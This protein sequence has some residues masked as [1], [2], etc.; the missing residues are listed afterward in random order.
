MPKKIYDIRPPRLADTIKKENQNLAEISKKRKGRNRA[1]RKKHSFWLPVL[2]IV[3]LVIMPGGIYLFFKLPRAE[4]TIWPKRE[5]LKF[6]QE[7][8]ADKSATL[9]DPAK[10]IIPAKYFQTSK[11]NAQDFP[12]TGSALNEGRAQGTITLYNKYSPPTPLTLRANT[13]FISDS[14]KIFITPQK[15][16]V[17]AATVSG[18][19]IVPGSVKIRVEAIEGGSDYNIGPANFSI[20]GLKGTAFYYSIY[21]V[22]ENAMTGGYAGKIK[23][24]TSEDI[25]TAKEVLTEKTIADTISNLK[26][27]LSP[28]YIL[29]DT[30]IFPTITNAATPTAAGTIAETFNYKVTASV[31]AIAFRKNDLEKYAKDFIISRIPEGAAM[32]DDSFKI[33]YTLKTIDISGGKEVIDVEFSSDIYYKIDKNSLTS[34]LL[35]ASPERAKKIITEAFG[36]KIDK[37]KI[38]LWPFWVNS[39]PNRKEAVEIKLSF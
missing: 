31:G 36:E 24:V 5:A 15:V 18:N 37:F 27:Q 35:G 20:P 11:T 34:F 29:F 13:R 4:V 16:V 21:G 3:V 33:N 32:L 30:A 25:Q 9:I 2:I 23:K 7:I 10:G 22:S 12:A 17:P 6:K 8:I 38:K 14:G 26:S 1:R 28:D 39:V 19:K